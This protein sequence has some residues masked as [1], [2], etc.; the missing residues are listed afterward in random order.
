[1][2]AKASKAERDWFDDRNNNAL[3]EVALEQERRADEARDRKRTIRI[4]KGEIA[5]IVDEAEEALLAAADAAPIMVRAGMLVQPIV[6]RLPASHDR[7]TDVTL[8]KP[9][10]MSNIVYLLNKHAAIFEQYDGR[11]KKWRVVDPP[12]S[13]A[14]QLLHKGRWRFPKVTGVITAPTLRPDGSILDRPGYDPATQLWYA[15]D[16]ALVMPPCK[17]RPSRR[18]AESALALLDELFSGF[19]FVSKVDESVASSAMLTSVLRGAFDLGP[20]YLFR[21]HD[22]GSGK[23]LAADLMSTVVRGLPCPVITYNKSMEEMEKRLGALVLE[24]VPMISLD[25]CSGDIGGDLLC[26]ITE[27]PLVRIRI[28][29]KSEAPE[30]DWRGV[31]FATGNNVSL[32]GDMTRRGLITNLD[33]QCERPELR[34]FRFDPIERVLEDRGAYVAAPITITRAYIAAGRPDVCE[35]P[36]GSYEQ[37]SRVVRSPLI[38]LGKADPVKSMDEMRQQDP[39]R[40]ALHSLINLWRDS[41][42]VNTPYTASELVFRANELA[43]PIGEHGEPE[44]E[45]QT[46]LRELLLQQAGTP[47]GDISTKALGNWLMSVHGRVHDRMRIERVKESRGH[48]NRYALIE[49]TED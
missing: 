39:G 14:T 16:R 40:R 49:I 25:N 32:V 19:P 35:T 43:N 9:L 44:P 26:Q 38:W 48:G 30:C 46:D 1:M 22:V 36:L 23:S 45:P 34:T 20:A 24:G 4:A 15:P 42:T 33:P 8:L 2:R 6:D 47:R 11:S 37:W 5:R 29:G 21:A 31:L 17:E 7:T 10:T 41:L 28:L 27:R 13:V 3:D 18:D 12:A